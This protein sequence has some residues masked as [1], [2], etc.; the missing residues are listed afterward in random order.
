MKIGW[1]I[2]KPQNQLNPQWSSFEIDK[3][4]ANHMDG[5]VWSCWRRCSGLPTEGISGTKDSDCVMACKICRVLIGVFKFQSTL[6]RVCT[7]DGLV[8]HQNPGTLT[9]VSEV[10]TLIEILLLLGWKVGVTCSQY[11]NPNNHLSKKKNCGLSKTVRTLTK[12]NA[13]T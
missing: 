8:L 1:I 13:F 2:S 5:D 7:T 4:L 9:R 10:V 6:G 11:H 3:P 12:G